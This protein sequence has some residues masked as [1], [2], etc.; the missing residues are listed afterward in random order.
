MTLPLFIAEKPN[1]GQQIAKNLPPPHKKGEGYIE[2]GGGV[3]T[4]AVGHILEQA[5]P[6]DYDPKYARWV[7]ADLP[8]LPSA[9]KMQA[10]PGKAKQIQVI[11]SL[12]K[13]CSSVVNAGDPGREGQLIVDEILEFLGNKK[14]V[15]RILLNSLDPAAVQAALAAL[16]PN[17][18]FTNLYQAALGRQRADWMVGM[19]MTRA[20][21][22]LG[23]QAGYSTVLSVGRVQ[24]PTLSIVV[25]RELE[26]EAFR[27]T[28]HW[29]LKIKLAT[30]PGFTARL[31]TPAT[32]PPTAGFDAA[33]RLIDRALATSI[34]A[35]AR[36]AGHATVSA[37]SNTPSSEPPPLPFDLSGIQSRMSAAQSAGVQDVLDACQSLY[38]KGFASYP[39]TDCTYL[40]ESQH[41]DA[42]G[43]LATL[44]KVFPA[45]AVP[46]AAADPAL[47]S[48]AWNDKKMGEHHAIIPT[49]VAPD[50]A[51]LSPLE[52]AVYEAVSLRYLAQFHPDCQVDKVAID[53]ECG[54]HTWSARGRVIQSP[55]WRT[56]FGAHET[57]DDAEPVDDDA[58]S[59]DAILPALSVADRVSVSDVSS[60]AKQ[61][62]PPPRY[63]EGTLLQA[64][65][66][67]DRLVTDPTEKK[68]LKSVEGIGRAATRANIINTLLKRG[69]LETKKKQLHPSGHARML[70]AILPPEIVDPGLTAR[71]ENALDAIAAGQV[72]LAAFQQ[73]QE[74]WLTA[75]ITTA[76][77]QVL[78]P[79]APGSQPVSAARPS[80][81]RKTP[82]KSTGK[83]ASAP[84]TGKA[85]SKC[86]KPMAQRTV[87][88]GPKTGQTFL[89]CTGYPACS[90]SEWPK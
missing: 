77:G 67:V 75:L 38:E 51:A 32:D 2:T 87:R 13:S 41:G 30:T 15:Q 25:R 50:I 68:K 69:F 79:P 29:L 66:H 59:D 21:T 70:I 43:V 28:D 8:I 55:G 53:L 58:E 35:A 48:R 84:A 71:W 57:D 78:P 39:R 23:R 46:I 33:G 74:S 62:K 34:Q 27:P 17:S 86:G 82:A 65:K 26:I 14:P 16:Q 6:E 56:V 88:N 63:T 47:K 76:R 61:T 5:Q 11:K 19:N 37:Y 83:T 4:W 80:A 12:L 85:C 18:N 22:L 1:M 54:G 7:L 45:H 60:D 44:A 64:M 36:Q 40:P 90:H 49:T 10:V 42:S 73:K 24:T 3:V 89:G 9:W 72:T 81:P 52:R 20:Y 31:K